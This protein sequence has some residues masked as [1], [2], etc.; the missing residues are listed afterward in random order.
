MTAMSAGRPGSLRRLTR[1]GGTETTIGLCLLLAMALVAVAAPLIAP[2]D[3]E[4]IASARVMA[5]PSLDSPFGWDALGR[6]VLSRILYAYRTSLTVAIG[7]VLLALSLGLPCGLAAGYFGGWVDN[8]LMRP[9]DLLLALPA[10]LL[11]VALIA[12]VGPG[13]LVVLLAIA[14]L[15][16]PILARVVRSSVLTVKTEPYVEGARA[17]GVGEAAIMVRHVLPNALGPALVQASVLMAFALQ[18]EAALS[19][20]GLGVQPPTP[21]LGRMIS[22]GRDVLVQAPWVSIFPGLAILL[23]VLSFNLIGDGLRRRFEAGGGS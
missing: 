5:P 9:L 14:F 10:M 1:L 2:H 6:D 7:S 19:F 15:Y 12:I 18:I 21:S 17:R 8:L 23:A 20:L 11:A 22:E 3:P 13:T 16:L 4:S